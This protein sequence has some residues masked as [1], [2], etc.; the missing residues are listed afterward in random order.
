MLYRL[1]LV[2][3]GFVKY[4]IRMRI[5]VRMPNWVGDC[6]MG[7]P[8]L[9]DLHNMHQGEI[10]AVCRGHVG[11]LLEHNPFVSAVVPE[12]VPGDIGYLLT[13]SLSSAWEFVKRGG[14]ATGRIFFMDTGPTPHK[15]CAAPER[16]SH[17]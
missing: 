14:A 3:L 10:V 13:N 6:V 7:L 2:F 5:V 1:F 4:P 9:E 15:T 12:A 16:D 8:V 17:D 11:A